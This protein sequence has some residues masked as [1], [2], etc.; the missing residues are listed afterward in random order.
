MATNLSCA[1]VAV[2]KLTVWRCTSAPKLELDGP[3]VPATIAPVSVNPATAFAE[4]SPVPPPDRADFTSPA[5]LYRA[6]NASIPPAELIEAVEVKPTADSERNGVV[7][8][9]LNCP[10]SARLPSP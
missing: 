10:T 8:G 5:P 3:I 6:M 2:V 9:A 4:S 1:P 7:V